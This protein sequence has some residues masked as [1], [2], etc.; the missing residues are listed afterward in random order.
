MDQPRDTVTQIISWIYTVAAVL[1][2]LGILS[3][4]LVEP[5]R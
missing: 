2:L 1:A 5:P 4:L 3:L